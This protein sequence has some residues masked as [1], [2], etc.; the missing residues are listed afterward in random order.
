MTRFSL[1]GAVLLA[2]G[3]VQSASAQD[4]S[5][6]R[7]IAETP[8]ASFTGSQY[9]DSRGCAYIRARDGGWYPRVT[10]QRKQMC[11]LTPS[12]SRRAQPT[13]VAKA[14]V[15]RQQVQPTVRRVVQQ[16]QRV[17][18]APAATQPAAPVQRRAT[19]GC[20]NA[21]ASSQPYINTG[22]GVRCGP[23][24]WTPSNRVTNT[25]STTQAASA[26]PR[27]V[28]VTPTRPNTVVT[29]RRIKQHPPAWIGPNPDDRDINA[30][31]GQTPSG[32]REVWRDDRLNPNRGLNNGNR[33]VT[34]SVA[35]KA[36]SGTYVQA[37]SFSSQ[38]S[39]SAAANALRA[40]GLPAKVGVGKTRSV[41]MIGPFRSE[42]ALQSALQRARS[43]GY[44]GAFIR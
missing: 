22:P 8:P 1:I 19:S 20:P 36:A 21:P 11:G 30:Q 25:T 35:P 26:Q 5:K 32:Y 13:Q 9:V 39:A 18:T 10:R 40:R 34:V 42:G 44:G 28:Q 16:P 41:I 4:L 7:P 2:I 31:N 33:K 14:P 43:A 6:A 23:Q 17:V 15:Q 27:A 29:S 38:A 3:T 24:Q 12:I 37:G